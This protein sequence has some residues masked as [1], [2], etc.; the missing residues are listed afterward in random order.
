MIQMYVR[1][2][3]K[4]GLKLP[5]YS[6][7]HLDCQIKYCLPACDWWVRMLPAYSPGY[8][9]EQVDARVE[10][11]GHADTRKM[12]ADSRSQKL[13]FLPFKQ[14][15]KDKISHQSFECKMP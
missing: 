3:K 11:V 13:I 1:K 10:E 7:N 4:L 5:P 6:D 12:M 14:Q 15:S 2:M 8:T 9:L